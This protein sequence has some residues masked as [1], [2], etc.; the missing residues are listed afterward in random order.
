MRYQPPP[1]MKEFVRHHKCR[2]IA[3]L[4][5]VSAQT[6]S[7]WCTGRQRV[8]AHLCHK[9]EELSGIP[10]EVLRPD[11]FNKEEPCSKTDWLL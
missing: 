5:G 11:V 9:V 10:K 1:G 7:N 8:S 3:E 6:V 2:T 4:L